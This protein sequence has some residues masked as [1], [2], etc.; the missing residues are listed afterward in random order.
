MRK[1]LSAFSF[2]ATVVAALAA[3]ILTGPVAAQQSVLDSVKE[4]GVLVAGVA[5]DYPPY[6]YV[7]T[8]GEVIGFDV[9]MVK[10]LAKRLGAELKIRPIA[11]ANRI[12]WLLNGHVDVVASSFSIT[13][14]REQV[15]D[16][17]MPCGVF[18][19]VFLVR[20]GSDIKGFADLAGKT[21]SFTQGTPFPEMLEREQ[22]N[23][24]HLV[25]QDTPQAVLAVEQ[26]KADAT[27]MEEGPAYMFAKDHDELAVVG[28][29][30]AGAAM[31]LAVRPNDSKWRD[32][33]NFTLI[34][35]WQDGSYAAA[36][37]EHLGI[38][39]PSW[40]RIPPY[41]WFE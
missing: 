11:T 22:P 12:P 2:S 26:G 39:P 17:T 35:M 20:K 5:A 6:S 24:K 40:F 15:V 28:E 10:Y 18:G 21:V 27:M 29:A 4:Q 25:F 3:M 31:G 34:E 9:D 16:F 7:T 32:Y 19:G 13:R 23:A 36:F 41:R 1:I 33:V 30:Y 38:E 8:S 37:R 14:P